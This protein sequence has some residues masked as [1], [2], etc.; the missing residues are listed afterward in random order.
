VVVGDASQGLIGTMKEINS[1]Y[2]SLLNNLSVFSTSLSDSTSSFSNI[3]NALQGSNASVGKFQSEINQSILQI[4]RLNEN[5]GVSLNR[6]SDFSSTT[7]K[8]QSSLQQGGDWLERSLGKGATDI[9]QIMRTLSDK[10]NTLNRTL[11]DI[12]AKISAKY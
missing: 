5:L 8:V 6:L 3:D 10:I 4:E 7:A 9:E 2:E 1:Q 11:D 12:R